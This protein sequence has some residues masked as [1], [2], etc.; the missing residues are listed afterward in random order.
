M[1]SRKTACFCPASIDACGLWRFFF[2]HLHL[3]GSR[4]LFTGGA[5]PIDALCE[6]DVICCQRM[7]TPNNMKFLQSMRAYGMHIIYDL[8]D[9]VWDL[10]SSNPAAS[11]FRLQ[12]VQDG[13]AACAE[14]ADVL[15]VSTSTLQKVV[16][17]N[18]G[19]LKNVATKKEIPVLVCEN[20][21]DPI[22]YRPNTEKHGKIIIGWCG[23]NTHAGDLQDLWPILAK[24]LLDYENVEVE[25]VGHN[26]PFKHPRL[27]Y[28][29]WVHVSE[30]PYVLRNW[31][32]D[33][34]LAPLESHR[35]NSSKSSIKMQEAG[36]LGRPCLAGFEKPYKDF[37]NLG[38]KDIKWQLCPGSV[39]YEFRLR[40]LIEDGPFRL[41]LGKKMYK[42]TLENFNIEQSIPEWET[43]VNACF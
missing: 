40:K 20:R 29:D 32:W 15:T 37:C 21:V 18:W 10:P 9:N 26:A 3:P 27:R 5:P 1:V 36:A 25:L 6:S 22:F 14:W 7:M 2:P 41:A 4:F 42:H 11:I 35:F 17:R 28:A 12:G 34:F 8:D 16:E 39:A 23:S 33:I 24:I 43:A 38:D 30:F 19:H 31:N 13:M